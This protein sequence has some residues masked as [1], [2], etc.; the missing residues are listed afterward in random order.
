MSGHESTGNGFGIS[1]ASFL[2]L[3]FKRELSAR[4]NAALE[5]AAF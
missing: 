3:G 2:R 5:D 1:V 4:E